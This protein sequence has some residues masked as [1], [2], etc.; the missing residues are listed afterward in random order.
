[1]ALAQ[2]AA[3]L[4]RCNTFC[5]SDH[6]HHHHH[7]RHHDGKVELVLGSF[8]AISRITEM[9]APREIRGF[10]LWETFS[11]G[12][13]IL[14]LQALNTPGYDF[15]VIDSWSSG[16]IFPQI[17][18]YISSLI[19][20]NFRLYDVRELLLC[21]WAGNVNKQIDR[22]EKLNFCILK[23]C[24]FKFFVFIFI[25]RNKSQNRRATADPLLV[26]SSF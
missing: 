26:C 15:Y 18:R 3:A 9:S 1:M 10:N 13:E 11:G 22:G 19:F 8:W 25:C 4:L 17:R 21:L 7:H 16:D 23:K 12:G 5:C 24:A 2:L 6:Q 14:C 20:C